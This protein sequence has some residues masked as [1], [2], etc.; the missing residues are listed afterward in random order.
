MNANLGYWLAILVLGGA[1]LFGNI[2]YFK[3]QQD[4]EL[5]Q[6][7]IPRTA[8]AEDL[9]N[10]YKNES[11]TQLKLDAA[12]LEED[13]AS[14]KTSNDEL[15]KEI[16]TL[17]ISKTRLEGIL[18]DTEQKVK[19]AEGKVKQL[20]SDLQ[21]AN[22]LATQYRTKASERDDFESDKNKREE[23]VAVLETEKKE[24]TNEKELLQQNNAAVVASAKSRI[25]Q[26][27]RDKANLLTTITQKSE[28]VRKRSAAGN[29]AEDVDGKILSLDLTS[30]FC[31]LDLGSVN[32]VRRGMRFQV[33]RWAMNKWMVLGTVEIKKVNYSTSDAVII[34]KPSV[35][36]QCPL[37]GYIAR[38]PEEVFS[39][40]AATKDNG[41][42]PLRSISA[43]DESSM[44]D[45]NPII[46]GDKIRN[47]LFERDKKL[48]FAF[49][50]EPVV[51]SEDILRSR[52]ET[53][54]NEYQDKVDIDTDFLILGRVEEA[55][56]GKDKDA[57]APNGDDKDA[58]PAAKA[59]AAKAF[60][61]QYGI[62]IMREVELNDFLR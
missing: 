31:V 52:I 39:P 36:K 14:A 35:I 12:K 45:S 49:A 41:V 24:L 4:L 11:V 56:L 47:P 21:E 30:K 40:Y 58:D 48:K 25:Q 53:S 20:E 10:V 43:D 55:T 16:D 34:D 42:V 7:Q 54:G 23:Q 13:L 62:P 44:S 59:Q 57:A 60:A 18:A 26:L 37:T 17:N 8:T 33:V 50:G 61:E 19:T 1:A 2:Q 51:F 5:K 38:D 15:K 32:N 29:H 6:L 3:Q 46:V 22:D 28:A 27:Q 9:V